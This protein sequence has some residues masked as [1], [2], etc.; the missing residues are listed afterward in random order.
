MS[1]LKVTAEELQQVSGQLN[2]TAG[3]ITAE[4]AQAL[5]LVNGLVGHG[6]EGAASGQF[7]ALFT[8]WKTSADQLIQSLEGISQLL[9]GAG[10]AYAE[11]EASVAKSMAG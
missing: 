1:Y 2:A 10:A 9:S 5:G 4:N 6:W 8:Q 3:S 11:T 7:Q